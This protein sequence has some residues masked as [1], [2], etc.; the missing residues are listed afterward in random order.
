ME[1]DDEYVIENTV[2]ELDQDPIPGLGEVPDCDD[3]EEGCLIVGP[4]DGGNQ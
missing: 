1:D 2:F 3:D 4:A